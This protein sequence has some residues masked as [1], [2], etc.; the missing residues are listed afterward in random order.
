MWSMIV[1]LI[2]MPDL[3]FIIPYRVMTNP[4]VYTSQI[5]GYGM[6][7]AAAAAVLQH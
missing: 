6:F 4:Y 5:P 2:V 3:A 1:W 7:S